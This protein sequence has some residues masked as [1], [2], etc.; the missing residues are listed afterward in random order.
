MALEDARNGDYAVSIIR[1][2]VVKATG[3]IP[4]PRILTLSNLDLLSGRFPVTYFYV[5]HKAKHNDSSASVADEL[6]NSL[7]N[8]LS[9]FYP[10]A[11]RIIPNP[12]TNEPEI[13][14][15]NTGALFL[16]AQASISLNQLDFYNL[17]KCLEG[18]LVPIHEEFPVQ[19]QLTNYE[20][21]GIF[22]TFTFD[23]ALG[24]A[25]SFTKFLLMWSEI[26]RKKPLS[27]SPDHRRYLLRARYPPIYNRSFDKSFISC[28]L[29]DILHISTPSTLL[30]RL[31]YIDASNIDRLQKLASLDGTKRTKIEA[32]SAYIWKIMVKAIDKGHSKKCKMGWLVD[33]RTR[34]CNTEKVMENY[35]G[36]ALSIAVGEASVNEIEQASI[37]NVANNVHNAISKVTSAEHFLD[38]IDWIECNKPGLVLA[39]I[40]LGQGGPAIVVSSGRRFPVAEVDFGFGSPVVGTVYSTIQKLGVGYINQRPGAKGDG[41]WTISAILWPEMIEA[42]ESDS[43]HVFQP[44]TSNHLK[45]L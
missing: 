41:S 29:H 2:S 38:L 22:I 25:S 4:E 1:K 17:N 40:V 37:A 12:E 20:C 32:F 9:H 34:I 23:H 8:C 21:G 19:V 24:D 10:F 33:G 7:A 35:I 39:K 31:Y 43:E 28:S 36:N 45:L 15:D 27:F 30:K 14:C 6:K 3:P 16:V 18:K 11:G 44:M 5:Y 26:A 13:L 42:L